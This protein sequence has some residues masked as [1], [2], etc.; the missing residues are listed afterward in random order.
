[1]QQLAEQQGV[2]EQGCNKE[3]GSRLKYY[4]ATYHHHFIA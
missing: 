1:M 4:H 3:K 2:Q